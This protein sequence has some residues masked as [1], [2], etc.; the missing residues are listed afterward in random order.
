MSGLWRLRIGISDRDIF[1][2]GE[3]GADGNEK[4]QGI[5]LARG[6]PPIHFGKEDGVERTL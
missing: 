4:Y 1:P 2:Y 6:V 5:L 3:G